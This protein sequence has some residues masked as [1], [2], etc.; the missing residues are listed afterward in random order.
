MQ[1]DY[2]HTLQAQPACA[3]TRPLLAHAGFLFSMLGGKLAERDENTVP[4]FLTRNVC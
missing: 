3:M 2:P 4:M 1:S